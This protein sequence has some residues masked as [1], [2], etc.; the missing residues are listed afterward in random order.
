MLTLH[1]YK[2]CPFCLRAVMVANYRQVDYKTSYLLNDDSETCEQLIGKKMVP[3]LEFA[4]GTAM[5][6]SLDIAQNLA[7]QGNPEREIL[8]PAGS[9]PFT[10]VFDALGTEINQLVFPR[11]VKIDQPEFKTA[12]AR[13]YFQKKKE[14]TIGMSFDEAWGITERLINAVEGGLNE[15]PAPPLPSARGDRLCWD[16]VFIYPTLRNL[17]MVKGLHFPAAIKQYLNEVAT[18]TNTELY[19]DEAV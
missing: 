17:T 8:A 13:A 16:D 4:D 7:E 9:A 19:F 15:L 11:N 3:I 5:A 12:S 1:I 10:S 18:L 6:E 14:A 2:H